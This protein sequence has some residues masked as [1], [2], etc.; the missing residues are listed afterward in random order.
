MIEEVQNIN[1]L[2]GVARAQAFQ[3]IQGVG[4][5]GQ[6]VQ[7]EFLAIFYKELLKQAFKPPNLWLEEK[8]NSQ[9]RNFASDMMVEKLSLELAQS[10]AFSG[11]NVF[12]AG[13]GR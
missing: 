13:L 9:M 1:S 5:G 8:D 10:Q 3:G 7:D 11:S 6:K 12:P 2:S 4:A